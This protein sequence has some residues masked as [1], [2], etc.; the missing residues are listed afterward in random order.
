MV[1]YFLKYLNS[2]SRMELLS[3][4]KHD[5]LWLLK[6]FKKLQNVQNENSVKFQLEMIA[7][8]SLSFDTYAIYNFT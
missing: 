6:P 3:L 7:P 2:K 8:L 4:N 5:G 1:L